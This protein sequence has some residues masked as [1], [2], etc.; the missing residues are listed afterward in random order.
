MTYN[1]I[2]VA[3]MLKAG[4]GIPAEG[5]QRTEWDAGCRPSFAN[6]EYRS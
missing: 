3:R 6:P 2:H 4:G 1:L 5:N